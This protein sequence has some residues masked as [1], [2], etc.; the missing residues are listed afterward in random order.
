MPAQ[1][2]V[3]TGLA[4]LCFDANHV[5]CTLPGSEP[6]LEQM[7]VH[8]VGVREEGVLL[9]TSWDIALAEFTEEQRRAARLFK[10]EA[11]SLTT[12]SQHEPSPAT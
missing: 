1:Y 6:G 12:D 5:R 9:T 3:N 4:Q 11:P 10:K 8:F 7:P 2:L